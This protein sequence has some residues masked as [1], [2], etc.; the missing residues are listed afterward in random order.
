[1]RFSPHILQFFSLLHF[2]FYYSY[3]YGFLQKNPIFFRKN[4]LYIVFHTAQPRDNVLNEGTLWLN[5]ASIYPSVDQATDP[6]EGEFHTFLRTTSTSSAIEKPKE[7]FNG[8]NPSEVFI[9]TIYKADEST[10]TSTWF[11]KGVVEDKPILEVMGE[12]INAESHP[13][14]AHCF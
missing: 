6:L 14:D 11:R 12:D 3:H 13:K 2:S 1:M 5:E 4:L 7:V 9:G 10:P 8:D